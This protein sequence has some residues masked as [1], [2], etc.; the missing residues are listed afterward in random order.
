MNASSIGLP[1][2]VLFAIAGMAWGMAMGISQDHSAMPAH[3]HLNL[4]GWVSLF[5]MG[6]YYRL[7]PAF[8][9]SRIALAQV[10]LWIAGSIVHPLGM[11]LVLRGHMFGGPMIGVGS[12]QL[13]VSMILFGWQ[14][15]RGET[16]R[17]KW[18]A[19]ALVTGDGR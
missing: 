5:L 18:Q 17:V 8:D 7:H 2:A 16:A 11:G 12:L 19:E 13:L 4:L 1:A 6:L 14:V 3:A 10:A 15:L 9:R